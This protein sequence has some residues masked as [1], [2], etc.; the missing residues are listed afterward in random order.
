MRVSVVRA[1]LGLLRTKGPNEKYDY[2]IRLAGRQKCLSMAWYGLRTE[3]SCPTE[4]ELLGMRQGQ[5]VGARARQLYPNGILI[6]PSDGKTV[7]EMT[8]TLMTDS[9]IQVLFEAAVSTGPLV[10]KA[11][12]L[13]RQGAGLA[14]TGK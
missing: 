13:Q 5:E 11:D 8:E 7:A 1:I 9:S 14:H 4:A 6:A 2:E 10:A 12:I 3:S